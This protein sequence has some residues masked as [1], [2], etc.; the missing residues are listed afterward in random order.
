VVVIS[1]LVWLIEDQILTLTN[2]GESAMRLSTWDP[3]APCTFLYARPE[4]L[5]KSA[6]TKLQTLWQA[7]Q[8]VAFV[9][10]EAHCALNWGD[11]FREAYSHIRRKLRIFSGIPKMALTATASISSVQKF[12]RTLASP[13]MLA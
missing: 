7:K 4:D 10:D 5:T 8:L 3:S 2:R 13:P 6:I 11:T 1:P 9:V 12:H